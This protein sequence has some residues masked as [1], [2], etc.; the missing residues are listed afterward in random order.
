MGFLDLL[1]AIPIDLGQG[2]VADRT[3]GKQIAM[4]LVPPGHGKKAL[5]VGCRAGVQTRWLRSRGYEVTSI[6]VDKRFDEALVVDANERLPFP[7]ESFDLVWCSE[8]IEHLRDPAAS[9]AEL[10]RVTRPGGELILTTPNSYAL[11]FRFIALFGLT[12]RRIQRKD[13]LHF[14]S[15]ADIRRLAPDAELFG[16]FPYAWIKRTIRRA[17][18]HLSPTFVMRIRKAAEAADEKAA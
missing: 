1:K 18:G 4:R 9:L 13:H 6:D 14:F 11:L 15:E 10:R 3:E 12:P 7:D 2:S 16:Y 17:I 5:D 8:V